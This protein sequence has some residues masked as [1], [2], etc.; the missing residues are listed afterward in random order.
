MD[1][2]DASFESVLRPRAAQSVTDAAKRASGTVPA[3]DE[4]LDDVERD[5]ARLEELTERSLEA[6]ESEEAGIDPESF[7]HAIEETERAFASARQMRSRLLAAYL[8]TREPT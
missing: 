1:R 7:R 4:I 5:L 3:F 2:I 8:S 6:A